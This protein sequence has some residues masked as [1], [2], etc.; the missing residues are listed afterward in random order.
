MDGDRVTLIGTYVPRPAAGGNQMLGHVS[1]LIGNMEVRL[2]TETRSTAELL[3]LSG[4]RVAVTGTLDLKRAS[5]QQSA[6]P[7]KAEKPV[8]QRP[9]AVARR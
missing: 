6:D 9:G 3:R 4:E 7:H 1:I 2:G 8:L 5:A